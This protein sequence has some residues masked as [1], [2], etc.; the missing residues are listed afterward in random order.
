MT[1]GR[2]IA[3]TGDVPGG[4]VARFSADGPGAGAPGSPMGISP[5]GVPGSAAIDTI[6]LGTAMPQLLVS[7]LERRYLD[8]FQPGYWRI[9]A[10]DDTLRPLLAKVTGLGRPREET[11]NGMAHALAAAH[12]HGHSVITAVHSEGPRQHI[13]LGGRRLAGRSRG[14]TEDYLAAQASVMRAH[15]PG[16]ELGAASPLDGTGTPELSAFLESAPAVAMITGIPSARVGSAAFQGIDRLVNAV[17]DRRYAIVVVAEPISPRHTDET[18]DLCRRLKSDVHSFVRQTVGETRGESDSVSTATTEKGDNRAAVAMASLY[19]L[20]A[21]CGLAGLLTGAAAGFAQPALMLA[22]ATGILGQQFQSR[23]SSTVSHSDSSGTSLTVE[24]LDA[25]AEACEQLLTR[26]MERIQRARADG[27]WRTSVYLAADE[28]ST[29]DAVAG[30]L[31]AVCSGEST[32][33]E[34]LRVVRPEPWLIRSAMTRGQT[35]TLRPAAGEQ[36]HP[37]GGAFDTLATCVTSGELAVLVNLPRN[38]IPGLPMREIGQFSLATPPP[39]ERSVELGLLLDPLG[40]RLDPMTLTAEALNR[41]VLICG[42][43]GY[44]KTTTAKNLLAEAYAGLGVPFLVI[45][46]VKAEYRALAGHP[47]LRGRLRVYSIGSDAPLPLRLNPFEPVA[48]VSLVRHIDLLKAVF[49]AAFPMYAGMPY[50]LEEAMLEVYTERGWNLFSSAN[51][52]LGPAP[53]AEDL[54]ALTPTL[55]DLYSKIDEVLDRKRYG[56]E[57][58]QNMGAALRARLKSLMVGSK[59]MALDTRRSVPVDELF[60]QP[61]VIELRNLGDDEEKSF[62]MALLLCFLYEYAEARAFGP[63]QE[64]LRHLTLIEESHRLLRAVRSSAGLEGA[65]AQAKAVTMFTDMLAEMRAY[66]EGFLIADQI[67]TKLA[68]E[69]LKN[70]NIKILHRLV[71]S[72]DRAAVSVAVNLTEAQSRHLA[73]LPPGQAIVHDARLAAPVLVGMHPLEHDAT[74]DRR[75]TVTG[76]PSNDLSYLHRNAGCHYCASPCDFIDGAERI[77]TPDLAPFLTEL[78]DGRADTAWQ[79]WSRWRTIWRSRADRWESSTATARSGLMYCA[80]TQDAHRWFGELVAARDTAVGA[81]GPRPAERIRRERAARWI[82]RLCAVLCDAEDFEGAAAESIEQV[83]REL[84][85]LLR[86]DPPSE[87]PGCAACPARCKALPLAAPLLPALGPAVLA[88]AT[89]PTPVGT[90]LRGL[91]RLVGAESPG[92]ARDLLYCLVTTACRD[93]DAADV[94][95]AL[96]RE[97]PGPARTQVPEPR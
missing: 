41:H 71:A 59:G 55:S 40:R 93:A 72:D 49:N 96:L 52:A 51:D 6:A 81:G 25:S 63:T 87:L 94:L 48:G 82:G 56:R 39:C 61:C 1:D 84:D 7:L 77:G 88:Q 28:E 86:S 92:Q 2:E 46:P 13:Y 4:S 45:E 27:W 26:H 85:T 10:P 29:L 90:R 9:S 53:S 17:G 15:L 43:T 54:S 58:H 36:G 37:L 32:S 91:A 60:T 57:V 34:P 8:D 44:G 11:L 76:A 69:T 20:A 97:E 33:L 30:A 70:S 50:V 22:G 66:G 19:G 35:L 12:W 24:R 89:T 3:L 5:G 79:A 62:V 21:F 75:D 64:R 65:D 31:R 16:L 78:I 14:S 23:S 67:P 42:M 18:L 74:G 83:G 38:D 68:P 47:A 80:A 73:T 95:T